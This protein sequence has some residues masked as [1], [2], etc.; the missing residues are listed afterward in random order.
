MEFLLF[1]RALQTE[2]FIHYMNLFHWATKIL[3]LSM[4]QTEQTGH[5]QFPKVI[6]TPLFPVALYFPI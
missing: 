2:E 4:P 5:L 3:S 6:T 1:Y